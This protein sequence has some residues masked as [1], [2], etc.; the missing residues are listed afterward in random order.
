[1]KVYAFVPAKGTSER[2]ESKNM[3]FLNGERLY[4]R[5]LKTLLKCKEID[6]VFLDTE[7]EKM[8]QMADYLPVT[9]MKRDKNLANNKTDGHQ[10][11]MNEIKSY[12]DADIYVQLLCTS[13]FIKPETIDKAVRKLKESNEYDSAVL[14]KKD[15]YYF[16]KNNKPTYH[17][18]HIPNSK[19]LP[20]TITEAMGLYIHKKDSALK[21]GRRYGQKPFLIYGHSD[22]LI[23]VNTPEDL[24]YAEIFAKG[25][26]AEENKR[27]NLIKHFISS[28]ALSDLLDDMKLE[29]GNS[30]GAV[31]PNWQCNLE[32]VKILGRANT[33]KLRKLNEGEDFRKIYDA[34]KSYE[35][36]AENDVICVENDVNDYAYFGSLNA[37]LAIRSGASA[38]VVNG[39]TRDYEETIALNYPVFTKN[40]NAADVRR[41]A[42]L[43][44]IN[45]PIRIDGHIIN[46]G[47]LIFI[48][49]CA[50]V[51]IYQTYEEEIIERVF[52]TF[53]NEKDII[54]DILE[55]KSV[56]EITKERGDF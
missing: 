39:A 19:D 33:L 17:I 35:G 47:D 28:P 37:Q 30:C 36:I 2:V 20:E 23:D 51:I 31:I 49:K 15:K 25:L 43:D 44:Y 3:R 8:Y 22:E 26:K 56:A 53:K 9:F 46:P 12:P 52:N 6:R 50:M 38:T 27:L 5:A 4:I 41:R 10:M 14:M 42:V 29:K 18:D 40:Y 34:L 1:M 7:S 21:T 11:F 45:K 48:D 32:N 16:W 54:T 13:P 55:K 24:S